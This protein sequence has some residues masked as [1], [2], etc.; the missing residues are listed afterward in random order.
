MPKIIG[1]SVSLPWRLMTREQKLDNEL[2][3]TQDEVFFLRQE[4]IGLHKTIRKLRKEIER[5]KT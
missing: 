5:E 2:A 1:N 3:L 4:I